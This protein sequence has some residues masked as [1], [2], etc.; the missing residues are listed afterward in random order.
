MRKFF[1][2]LLATIPF[3]FLCCER[4]NGTNN[5]TS[6]P[7]RWRYIGRQY[8]YIG[9]MTDTLYDHD[10]EGNPV[11]RL[12]RDSMFIIDLDVYPDRNYFQ[13]HVVNYDSVRLL[14]GDNKW[15]SYSFPTTYGYP[16]FVIN[17]YGT[18]SSSISSFY[19][20]R[21]KVSKHTA[22]TLSIHYMYFDIG[23]NNIP[24]SYYNFIRVR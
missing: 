5:N 6:R 21:C 4:E 14:F 8:E 11:Y 15:Y 1:F 20:Y 17:G 13:S 19:G 18:D 12:T 24:W 9:N 7:E 16:V 23:Y 22:D 3:I 10:P 2:L